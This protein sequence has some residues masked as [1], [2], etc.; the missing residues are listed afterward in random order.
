MIE[1]RTFT[2][3]LL[4]IL[5]I[6]H[7]VFSQEENVLPQN[8]IKGHP[9]IEWIG[10]Y[11]DDTDE[12][13]KKKFGERLINFLAGKKPKNFLSKPVAVYMDPDDQLWILD[14]AN[15]SLIRV[16]EGVGEMPQFRPKKSNLFPSLVGICQFGKDKILFTDTYYNRIFYFTP[17]RKELS[18]LSD[19]LEFDRPTG[20]AY[21]SVNQQI[22]VVETNSHRISILDNKGQLIRR[23]GSR[24]SAPGEFN[25]PTSICI[26]NSGKVFIVDALNFRVQVFSTDGDFLTMFGKQGDATGFFAR[27]KGI[28]TDSQGNIYVVDALFNTVQVFDIE[29][30]FL[31]N[32]GIQG[33]GEGEFWLPNGIYIDKEEHIYIADTY[34]SRIQVFRLLK[35]N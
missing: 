13:L 17:G 34:N 29:G 15:Q 32:F 6:F 19:T 25:F 5:N 16:K 12:S 14:Q 18:I 28:A 21:S 20:I 22:W 9:R 11:P 2:L 35:G 30:N 1:Y 27:P 24:G 26:D 7:P 23:F 31:E 4:I 33:R 8:H 10:Q 3:S